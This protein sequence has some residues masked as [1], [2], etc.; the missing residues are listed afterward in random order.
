MASHSLGP[1]PDL[2]PPTL[3]I[4]R[5]TNEF[6]G[7]QYAALGVS[8]EE[9]ALGVLV[10]KASTIK[11]KMISENLFETFGKWGVEGFF[12][13]LYCCFFLVVGL[14]LIYVKLLMS[15]PI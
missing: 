2:P 11:V 5:F 13:P 3:S 1:K 14:L 8:L 10:M 6:R 9:E 7:R 15:L 4:I 12:A